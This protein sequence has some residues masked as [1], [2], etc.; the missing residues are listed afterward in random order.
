M[1]T[2]KTHSSDARKYQ[3]VIL[4]R[5]KQMLVRKTAS[6]NIVSSYWIFLLFLFTLYNS[7]DNFEKFFREYFHLAFFV[8]TKLFLL[9]LIAN[10]T[11]IINKNQTK[12]FTQSEENSRDRCPGF[13]LRNTLLK[14]QTLQ[15]NVGRIPKWAAKMLNNL[16]IFHAR[17]SAYR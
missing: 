10:S 9:R 2:A 4:A 1:V 12:D 16:Q 17:V 11:K 8:E 7:I 5:R 6:T 15:P 13:M 14:S 3:L